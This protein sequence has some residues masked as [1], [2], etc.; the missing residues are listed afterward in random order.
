MATT[1]ESI[2]SR[3][4]DNTITNYGPFKRVSGKTDQSASLLSSRRIRFCT[5]EWYYVS[6][7]PFTYFPHCYFQ[8]EIRHLFS[9][10]LSLF[11]S[12]FKLFHS[13]ITLR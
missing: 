9:V 10:F 3:Q 1:R 2:D 13:I 8:I 6:L 4:A 11:F 12:L 7:A 5:G